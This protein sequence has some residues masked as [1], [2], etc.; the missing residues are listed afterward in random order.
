M[1]S[2][3]ILVLIYIIAVGSYTAHGHNGHLAVQHV[4]WDLLQGRE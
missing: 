2:S 4:V 3:P 1:L